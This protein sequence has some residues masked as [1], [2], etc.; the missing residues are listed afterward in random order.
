MAV[1]IK[2]LPVLVIVSCCNRLRRRRICWLRCVG[3]G[4]G[5]LRFNSFLLSLNTV[6]FSFFRGRERGLMSCF[7]LAKVVAVV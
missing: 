2:R 1:L 6:P 7:C 3:V 4:V 5:V